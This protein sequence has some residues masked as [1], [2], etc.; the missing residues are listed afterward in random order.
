MLFEKVVKN[1]KSMTEVILNNY[2]EKKYNLI[3][4]LKTHFFY[5]LKVL[6][7]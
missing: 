3:L 5:R 6:F 4:T 1:I 7:Q 2:H